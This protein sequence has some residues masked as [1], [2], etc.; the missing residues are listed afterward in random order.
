MTSCPCYQAFEPGARCVPFKLPQAIGIESLS[1]IEGPAAK[2]GP[3][4]LRSGRSN[5]KLRDA[6]HV[7][8]SFFASLSGG[9]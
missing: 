5:A 9:P 3:R 8:I 2:R 7:S 6:V 4:Q 1:K